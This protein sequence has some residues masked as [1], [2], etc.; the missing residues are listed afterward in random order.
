MADQLLSQADVDAL[1]SSLTRSEPPKPAA[2]ARQAQAGPAS[3]GASPKNASVP[4]ASAR[5]AQSGGNAPS[6]PA[7]PARQE[8]KPELS[9]ETVNAMNAKIADLSRQMAQMGAVLKRIESLEKKAAELE[10]KI[11]RGNESQAAAQRVQEL[12]EAVKRISNNLKGTPGYGVKYTFSCEKCSDHG[13]VAV[14][15]RCTKCGHERWYGWWP[16]KK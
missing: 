10:N 14:M 15:Y 12:S 9:S 8:S 5:Q 1:V 2:P 11:A 16:E 4:P 13:H 6:R 3:V 7:Q